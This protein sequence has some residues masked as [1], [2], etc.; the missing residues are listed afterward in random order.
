MMTMATT[1]RVGAFSGFY[2]D[3]RTGMREVVYGDPIDAIY[4]DYLAEVT[5][6]YFYAQAQEGKPAYAEYF[7]EQFEDVAEEF[8]RRK[9]K[10]V[11]NAGALD[12]KGLAEKIDQMCRDKGFNLK[13]AYIYGDD[14]LP[15]YE[16]LKSAGDL[17][18]LDIA[19]PVKDWE[20]LDSVFIAQ[21]Y[22]GARGIKKALQEGADIVICGRGTDASLLVGIAAWWY[23][24]KFSEFDK[25]ASIVIAGHITECG[26][27]CCGGN[28]AG[29]IDV[30]GW[31]NLSFPIVEIEEDGTFFITKESKSGGM[32]ND[33]TVIAQIV[34]EIQGGHYL[35]ADVT[36]DV[37]S[38]KVEN[39]G[40]DRVKVHSVKG[41]RQAH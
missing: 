25:L 13:V 1:L 4:G 28:F 36:V 32:V 35:N 26:A 12:P 6:A 31:K 17:V 23:D 24:W 27:H 9:L 37:R 38:V 30:P 20:Y 19:A 21:A 10:L 11:T 39:V 18:S 3:R 2:G 5:L 15:K 34:Y 40:A 41:F 16:Q 8:V 33:K 14:L 22:F 29:F 7:I